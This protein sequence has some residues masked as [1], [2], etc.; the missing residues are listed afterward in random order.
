MSIFDAGEREGLK[1]CV[2]ASIGL[3]AALCAGYN[4]LAY[5]RRGESRLL[6]NALAYA[7]LTAVEIEHTQHHRR[8]A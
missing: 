3:L 4:A 5:L 7:A 6:V 2:H 8:A 1:G